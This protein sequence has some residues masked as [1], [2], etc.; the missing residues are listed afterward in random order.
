MVRGGPGSYKL[1]MNDSSVEAE[2]HT[3]RDGGLLMQ[4]SCL[5]FIAT[6]CIYLMYHFTK[7]FI[8]LFCTL[9]DRSHI[10]ITTFT[11]VAILIFF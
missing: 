2:I 11:Y 8:K 10:L 3:L 6:C 1:K 9:K 4:V 7:C 5:L